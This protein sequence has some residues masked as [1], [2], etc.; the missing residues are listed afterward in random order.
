MDDHIIN[1]VADRI[2]TDIIR[3]DREIAATAAAVDVE[4]ADVNELATEQ[5]ADDG[6]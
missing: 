4:A 5:E 1:I 6:N 2:W 3:L